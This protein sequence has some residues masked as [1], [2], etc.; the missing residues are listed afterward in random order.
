MIPP[1]VLESAPVHQRHSA[2]YR[3]PDHLPAGAVLV[4]GAGSSG[5][6]IAEELMAAGRKVF[7]SVGRHGHPP[8]RYR[9]RYNVWWLGVLGKWD[10][11]TPA[12]APAPAPNT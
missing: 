6:E 3:N 12:P 1:L 2:D 9:G 7:L 10:M 8:R 11:D 5:A 4:V